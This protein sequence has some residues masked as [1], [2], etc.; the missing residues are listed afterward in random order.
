MYMA[1]HSLRTLFVASVVVLA[2]CAG[3]VSDAPGS[4][5]ADATDPDTASTTT[6]DGNQ[7]DTAPTA[8]ADGGTV[9]FYL[10]DEK[11]AIG[12]FRHLNVTVTRVGFERRAADGGGWVEREVDN[13][14]VDLTKLQGANATL[15]DEY[16]L[17]N[18]AYGKVFVHVGEVDATLQNGEQ[19]RVKLPSEKLQLTTEFT[20]D[21]SS[22]VDFVFDITVHEA[23]KSGKYVL[24]PVVGE[25]GTDI[26]IEPAGDEERREGLSLQFVGDVSPGENVTVG[27]TRGGEAVANATVLVNGDEV[28]TTAA[29]G[30]ITVEVPR[31]ETVTVEAKQDDDQAELEVEFERGGEG[32][33]EERADD[34]AEPSLNA[35]FVGN[36]TRGESVTVSV[37]RNGSGVA[38]ATVAVNDETVGATGET[39][40]LTFEVPDAETLTVTV[41]DGDEAVELEREF[42]SEASS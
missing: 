33:D 15:V 41:R 11:N 30:R 6:A 37:T 8:A 2:G 16:D 10:S 19:V 18:G 13:A 42:G 21:N 40:E 1:R 36:V 20:V 3:G 17:P 5:T 35:T 27:V 28:G 7:T 23:G 4:P 38:N 25:S 24:K 34:E 14:T 29:D 31:E 39:G 22:A 26:P 12:E 32:E 9:A